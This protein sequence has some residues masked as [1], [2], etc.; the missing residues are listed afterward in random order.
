MAKANLPP[1]ASCTGCG[2]C[3]GPV[4][5]RRLEAKQIREVLRETGE[6]W[7]PNPE[8][9][10]DC[11]FLRIDGETTR[12]AVYEARP[13]ACRAFGVIEQMTCRH[14]PEEAQL[15]LSP[16]RAVELRLTDPA[17]KLLGEHFESGYLERM[18]SLLGGNELGP[19][20]SIRLLRELRRTGQMPYRSEPREKVK[21]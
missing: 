20:E 3:C 9:P 18:S 17:D 21:L 5:V 14:F 11:G 15:D 13:F 4:A 7:T 10:M 19:G 2:D 12:C 16:Q 1:M 8:R 6:S